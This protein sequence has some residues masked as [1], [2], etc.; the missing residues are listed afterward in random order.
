MECTHARSRN[1]N[2]HI[3]SSSDLFMNAGFIQVVCLLGLLGLFVV[4]FKKYPL[5]V[6]IRHLVMASFFVLVS[7]VLNALSI[8]IPFFGVPSVKISFALLPLMIAGATLSPSWAYLVGLITDLI[9]LIITPTQFPFFGFTLNHVLVAV[10]PSLWYQRSVKLSPQ[11]IQRNI[12]I[13]F[14]IVSIFASVYVLQMD[15]VQ[16]DKNMVEVTSIMKFGIV[17]FIIVMTSLMLV[18]LRYVKIKL[19]NQEASELAKWM[20]VPLLMEVLISLILTPF[21]LQTMYG[22]PWFIS[23]FIRVVKAC[24]MIPLNIVVGYSL[25][26]I[27]KRASFS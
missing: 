9:G 13:S 23:M 6:T 5:E 11:A 1:S 20:C 4:I 16:I 27:I 12:Y 3:V 19:D 22:I 8:M 18:I 26:K 10:I 14:I 2:P 7:V 25:L 17:G 15:A 21:W 24:V